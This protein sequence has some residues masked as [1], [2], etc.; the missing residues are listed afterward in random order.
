MEVEW[1][2]YLLDSLLKR[3]GGG[4]NLGQRKKLSYTTGQQSLSHPGGEPGS[5]Y[6]EAMSTFGQNWWVVIPYL[7]QYQIQALK[8]R[9]GP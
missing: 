3:G 4:S 6:C 2:I 7:T 5:E 8:R 9:V 1:R